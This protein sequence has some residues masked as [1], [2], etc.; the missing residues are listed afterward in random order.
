MARNSESSHFIVTKIFFWEISHSHVDRFHKASV[1]GRTIEITMAIDGAVVLSYWLV[2]FNA[3]PNA[4]VSQGLEDLTNQLSWRAI[5][6]WKNSKR[7][8][9][10]FTWLKMRGAIEGDHSP[11]DGGFGH[12]HFASTS[13]GHGGGLLLLLSCFASGLRLRR[14]DRS[15]ISVT[16]ST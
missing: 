10:S 11:S 13:D 14:F 8:D 9:I 12:G 4:W 2:V 7:R 16:E 1:F 5:G 3:N 6:W 15:R